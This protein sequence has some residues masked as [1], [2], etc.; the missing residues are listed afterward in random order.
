M[1]NGTWHYAIYRPMSNAKAV[2]QLTMINN[3]ESI[4]RKDARKVLRRIK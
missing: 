4:Y 3:S 2:E 1:P